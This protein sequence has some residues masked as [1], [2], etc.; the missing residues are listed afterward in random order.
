[1]DQVPTEDVPNPFYKYSHSIRVC[2]N[3]FDPFSIVVCSLFLHCPSSSL[4]MF[5]SPQMYMFEKIEARNMMLTCIKFPFDVAMCNMHS[6]K[7]NDDGF[8]SN[9]KRSNSFVGAAFSLFIE[10]QYVIVAKSSRWFK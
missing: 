10:T 6:L 8:T 3:G 4:F 7:A 5:A 9:N 2:A 1:M